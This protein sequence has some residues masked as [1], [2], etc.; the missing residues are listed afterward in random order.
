MRI[1]NLTVVLLTIAGLNSFASGL[2]KDNPKKACTINISALDTLSG[3]E[4]Y[5]SIPDETMKKYFQT[6]LTAC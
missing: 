6:N 1:L 2:R 5:Y 3:Y 4:K